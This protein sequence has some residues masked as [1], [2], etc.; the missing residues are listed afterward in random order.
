VTEDRLHELSKMTFFEHLAELRTRLIYVAITLAVGFGICWFFVEDL[1]RILMIPMIEVLGPERKM[2]F[3]NPTEA[4][5]TY[6]KVAALGGL[7]ITTP[8]WL[9]HIWRFIAPGLYKNERKYIVLFVLFGSIFFL[10]GSLFGYFRIIPLGFQ[11]L[12]NN[13]QS[14]FFEA[15][16]SLKETFSISTRLLIAFGIAFELPLVIFFFARMGLVSAGWLLRKFKY[17]VLLI[18]ITAAMLTPPDWVTQIGLGIPM[19]ILY[20][21]GVGVAAVFGKRKPKE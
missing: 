3:T 21:L 2:I 18:F 15:L 12:I 19:C 1:F 4:F 7:M 11:F 14:S 9:Y 16:P 5:V 13:F 17:A 8:V 6:L 10:G 20:L